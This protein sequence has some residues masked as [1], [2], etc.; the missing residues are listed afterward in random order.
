[1]PRLLE[2]E[3]FVGDT[4]EFLRKL[5][6]GFDAERTVVMTEPPWPTDPEPEAA[7]IW[8]RVARLMPIVACRLIVWRGCRTDPRWT[9]SALPAYFPFLETKWLECRSPS[10]H[11]HAA[12]ELVS[13]FGRSAWA[14]G[15]PVLSEVVDEATRPHAL[16]CG[17]GH[18]RQLVASCVPPG[19]LVFDPFCGSGTMLVAAAEAGRRFVGV[20]RCAENVEVT[21]QRLRAIAS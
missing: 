18:A 11:I 1:M 21:E 16:S 13:I 8:S 9:T 19:W 14:C 2:N 6:G 5:G 15:P 3:V 17:L 12:A 4:A 10:G 20:D 7:S